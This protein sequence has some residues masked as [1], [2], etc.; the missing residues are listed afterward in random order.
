[1]ERPN[2]HMDELWKVVDPYVDM[3]NGG[4]RE[5]APEAVKEAWNEIYRDAW[6]LDKLQ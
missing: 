5:D 1:M 6:D 2:K 4:I 3:K